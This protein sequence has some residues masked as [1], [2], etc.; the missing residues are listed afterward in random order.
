MVRYSMELRTR[1][2][3]KGYEFL[4]FARKYEKTM[5]GYRTRFFKNCFQ[6]VAHKASEFL[7]NKIAD[8]VTKWNDNK[9]VKPDEK[10]RNHEKIIIPLEKREE[11]SKELRK[12]L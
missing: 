3:V 10:P 4:S 1:K 12:V 5:I 11:I 8:A 2:Y 7:G 6:K 9:I